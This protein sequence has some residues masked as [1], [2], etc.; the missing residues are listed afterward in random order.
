MLFFCIYSAI[1]YF[2]HL[3][4][5][6]KGQKSKRKS[7]KSMVKSQKSI[8]MTFS[9]TGLSFSSGKST[10]FTF[11]LFCLSELE[12]H[13][14]QSKRHKS[15]LAHLLISGMMGILYESKSSQGRN[16]LCIQGCSYGCEQICWP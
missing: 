2:L 5:I 10:S 3:F 11:Q 15:N 8:T 14:K 1:S 13:Q 16:A 9:S 6:K 12:K 4:S 7:Q